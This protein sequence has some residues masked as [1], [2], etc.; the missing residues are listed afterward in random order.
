MGQRPAFG[1]M[2]IH[3]PW[4]PC[5]Y[6][7]ALQRHQEKA[8]KT[9]DTDRPRRYEFNVP[10]EILTSTRADVLACW[11]GSRRGTLLV[12]G[13]CLA[14]SGMRAGTGSVKTDL[15]AK[16]RG[17]VKNTSHEA[18]NGR[19]PSKAKGTAGRTAHSASKSKSAKLSQSAHSRDEVRRAAVRPEPQRVQEIQRALIQAG[20]LH[21]GP[22]GQWDE[23]TRDAM[24]RYQERHGFTMTGLP[25]SKSL[26]E[27]G[28]GPHPLPPGVA[29]ATRANLSPPNTSDPLSVPGTEDSPADAGAP[30]QHR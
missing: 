18:K 11:L 9:L 14:A 23:A 16:P 3:P 10:G 30:Q 13:L 25:D 27:M 22:T 4:R 29:A 24:R 8:K 26:M 6:D 2:E 20:E 19:S 17:S 15:P 21:E 7:T 12:V 28:L 5:P 1:Q